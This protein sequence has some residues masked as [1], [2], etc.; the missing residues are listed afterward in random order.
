MP[1]FYGTIINDVI[2]GGG[3]GKKWWPF[4]REKKNT[5]KEAVLRKIP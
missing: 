3:N 5:L 4:S 2:G 1:N